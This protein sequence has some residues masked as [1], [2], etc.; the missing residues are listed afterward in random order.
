MAD[1]SGRATLSPPSFCIG[2][3]LVA[4]N[5]EDCCRVWSFEQAG[6]PLAHPQDFVC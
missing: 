2:D 1:A 4:K 5:L 6:E 3:R